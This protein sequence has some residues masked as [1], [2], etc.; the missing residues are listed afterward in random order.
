MLRLRIVHRFGLLTPLL[1]LQRWADGHEERR[2]AES[3]P[4][5]SVQRPAP[6][7]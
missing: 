4:S 3:A 1:R 5:A 7:S 6:L 2:P